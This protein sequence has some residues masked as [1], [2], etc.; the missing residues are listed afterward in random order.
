MIQLVRLP[1]SST[2]PAEPFVPYWQRIVADLRRKIADGTYPPG[3]RLP[4]TPQ[5][6]AAYKVAPAT[7][8]RAVKVL[9]EA[10]E[11]RGHQGLGVF[12]PG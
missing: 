9:L 4:S 1:G 8:R 5:L 11:L 7:V 6:A 12:V 2:V 10:E 3:S